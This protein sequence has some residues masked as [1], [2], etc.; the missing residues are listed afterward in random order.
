MEGY[1]LA[2][3]FTASG[4]L[5]TRQPIFVTNLPAHGMQ[6]RI[7]LEGRNGYC[8]LPLF[9]YSQGGSTMKISVSG[10]TAHLQG[11]WTLNGLTKV[12]IESLAV[13]YDRRHRQG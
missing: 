6:C 1:R 5:K 9:H 13:P 2:V 8:E 11:E 4:L 3:T 12:T 7:N 10:A